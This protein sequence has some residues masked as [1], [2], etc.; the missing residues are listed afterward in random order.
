MDFHKPLYVVRFTPN[1]WG[2]ARQGKRMYRLSLKYNSA[3]YD[4]LLNNAMKQRYRLVLDH[5]YRKKLLV[6]YRQLAVIYA[7]RI[8]V[9]EKSAS[10]LD[11]DFND[12]VNSEDDDIRLQL[13]IINL[14]NDLDAVDDEI[15]MSLT[16]RDQIAFDTS[17]FINPADIRAR[18]KSLDTSLN[19][20]NIHLKSSRLRMGYSE[21]RFK[22]EKAENRNY[23]SYFEARVDR[24]EARFREGLSAGLGIRIPIVNP[25][26]L[27]INRRRLASMEDKARYE[28]NKR[29][30]AEKIVANL[31]D[32]DRLLRQHKI[33][34]DKKSG[35]KAE[36]S[37]ALY[38]KMDGVNPLI[39]LKLKES[40][41]QIEMSLLKIS[42]RV[43]EE[44]INLLDDAGS[45]IKRPFTNYLSRDKETFK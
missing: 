37:L 35:S 1:G 16:G 42:F 33:L 26:R 23:L 8:N 15:R 32:L 45:L 22:L 5:L 36:S 28:N 3:E 44:Y 31:Q 12:L 19:P 40:T 21:A 27:D 20:D 39:L 17:D 10:G 6:F 18:L 4:L 38:S 30:L 9:L 43:L 11:F 29:R 14:E 7:D 24:D 2:E 25:N 34:T 41:L 13:D